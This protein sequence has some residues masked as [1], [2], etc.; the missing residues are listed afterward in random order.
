MVCGLD[1]SGSQPFYYIPCILNCT[2]TASRDTVA[3]FPGS[4]SPCRDSHMT[5][6]LASPDFCQFKG[7]AGVSIIVRAC[8]CVHVHV[9]QRDSLQKVLGWVESGTKCT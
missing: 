5:F 1:H 2:A 6:E 8:V 3:S 4:L 7:H 9:S